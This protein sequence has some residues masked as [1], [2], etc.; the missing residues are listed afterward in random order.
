MSTHRA[1]EPG[2]SLVGEMLDPAGRR[3][4]WYRTTPVTSYGETIARLE[5][6]AGREGDDNYAV[7]SLGETVNERT[8]HEFADALNTGE[9]CVSLRS[10]HRQFDVTILDRAVTVSAWKHFSERP[11]ADLREETVDAA[12]ADCLEEI[13]HKI[14]RAT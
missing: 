1:S 5:I 13:A 10:D 9:W 6:C 4:V 8:L 7:L 2:W 14:R 11:I 3:G 12:V